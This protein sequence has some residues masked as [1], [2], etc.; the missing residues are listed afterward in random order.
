MSIELMKQLGHEFNDAKLF[1]LA[2]THCS[3]NAYENNE[4]LEFL[5]DSIINFV[6]AEALFQQFPLLKEGEL[7][8]FRASLVNRTMLYQIAQQFKIGSYLILGTGELKSGGHER[9]SILS[10]AMEALIGAIYLDSDFNH[11][12]QCILVW[13]KPFLEALT[14]N[15]NQKDPKTK[16][17]EYLQKKRLALPIYEVDSILGKDHDQ[18]F[19]IRCRIVGINEEVLGI[20]KSRRSAEQA[21]AELMLGKIGHE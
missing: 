16:L 2:L 20:G 1:K 13:Y 6:I 17:Q 7:T 5:G 18:I 14:L 11:T 21:A 19:R 4:R 3:S 15:T 12:R 10:C 8:R 9:A